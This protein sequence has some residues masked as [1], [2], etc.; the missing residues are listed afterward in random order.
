MSDPELQMKQLITRLY[1]SA[2]NLGLREGQ[3]PCLDFFN[4]E[5]YD[6]QCKCGNFVWTGEEGLTEDWIKFA[7]CNSCGGAHPLVTNPHTGESEPMDPETVK[8]C[9][10]ICTSGL[11]VEETESEE[12][13]SDSSDSF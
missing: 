4:K 3:V 12:S 13:D 1:L 2:I 5:V 11:N 7:L 8:E 9:I 6:I 10:E